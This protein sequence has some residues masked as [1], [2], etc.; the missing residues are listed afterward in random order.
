MYD[1]YFLQTEDWAMFWKKNVALGHDFFEISFRDKNFAFTAIV[2]K[3][4]WHLNQSFLYLPKGPTFKLLTKEK[5]SSFR[6]SLRNFL[7]KL[8]EKARVEN[9]TFIKLEFG[10]EVLDFLRLEGERDLFKLIQIMFTPNGRLNTSGV[11]VFKDVKNI[12]YLSTVTLDLKYLGQIDNYTKNNFD[13]FF[14]NS[15]TFFSM[16]NANIRRYTKKSLNFGWR[17]DFAKNDKNFDI[18]WEIYKET[19][20]RQKFAVHDKNYFRGLVNEDF[21]RLILLRDSQNKPHCCWLGIVSGETIYYLYGGNTGESFKNYGQY[22]MHL[23][24]MYLGKIENL[25][26]YDLGGYD[27]GKGFGKFKEGYRGNIRHF[28]KPIDIVILP[29]KYQFTNRFVQTAKNIRQVLP[30]S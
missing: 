1:P 10:D 27:S 23:V 28:A 6:S 25:S 19:S 24:I 17:V 13:A 21:S 4:P 15:S 11:K 2:Y 9:C 26:Y 5:K 12:Q 18:F 3:Y 7:L 16:T 20:K 30:F 29:R 8:L 22:F 14:S